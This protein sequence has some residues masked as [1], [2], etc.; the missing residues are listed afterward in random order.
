[1]KINWKV[2]GMLTTVVGAGLS[3][4]TNLVEDKKMD[5]TI[6]RKVREALAE[7]KENEEEE[8]E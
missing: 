2:I 6:D 3:L 1:M 4:V 8:S 5:E 7:G